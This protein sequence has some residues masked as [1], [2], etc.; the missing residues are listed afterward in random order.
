VLSKEIVLIG[1]SGHGLV[2]G[3]TVLTLGL[4][5]K[6]YTEVKAVEHNLFGLSYLGCESAND[7]IGWS[8]DYEYVLGI[9]NNRIRT[10]LGHLVKK[11]RKS[12]LNVVHPSAD[13]THY[14]NIGIGNFVSKQVVVNVNASIGD[15]CILNTGSIIEHDCHI[16]NGVHIAPGAV[17]AGNV[18]VG[19]STFV[20]ANAV[21][22][23]GVTIGRNVTIG[24]GAVIIRNIPDNKVVVGNPSREL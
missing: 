19:D 20:G 17:L 21:I 8:R 14:M 4:P 13:L 5:L 11:N 9:G 15:F 6:Y 2:V 24:A 23:Q 3:D 16:G 18:T 7:F 1:Y 22:K 10:E 12:L